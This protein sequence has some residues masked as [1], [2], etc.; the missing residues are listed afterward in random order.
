MKTVYIDILFVINLAVDY[1]VVFATARLAGIR[2]E[3]LR[4]LLAAILGALYSLIIFADVSETV[5]I[6]TKFAVSAIMVFVVFGKRKM[7]DFLRVLTIFYICGFLFSGFMMLINSVTH[8]R[9]FFVKS[10]IV[11]FEFSALEIVISGTAAFVVTEILHRIFRRGEP[12]GDFFAKVMYNGKTAVLKGFTDT[13]NNLCE[14]IS[15]TPVAITSPAAIKNI[16]PENMF[17]AMEN[18]SLSMEKGFYLVPCKTVS[19]SVLIP[20]FRPEKLILINSDGEFE[21]E[22]I[23]IAVSENVPENTLIIGKNII[24]KSTNKIFSEV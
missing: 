11:Y 5:F 13:G 1:L 9:S 10:G 24:L 19:G 4:G 22:N 3:R 14:P 2:F 21:A 12:E 7:G 16:V 6:I 8:S 23:M 17:C 15:G 20:A 18:N